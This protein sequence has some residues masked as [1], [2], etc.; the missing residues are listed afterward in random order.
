MRTIGEGA[1]MPDDRMVTKVFRVVNK[2][3][4][5]EENRKSEVETEEV[6]QNGF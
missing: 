6:K 1:G 5:E 3:W 4:L 2:K